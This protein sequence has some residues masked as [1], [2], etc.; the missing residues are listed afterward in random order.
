M[1]FAFAGHN[2]VQHVPELMSLRWSAAPK[3]ILVTA[4]VGKPSITVKAP[5]FIGLHCIRQH[6]IF[7]VF[8]IPK[9]HNKLGQESLEES[10]VERT[11]ALSS[12]DA[13]QVHAK[14]WAIYSTFVYSSSRIRRLDLRVLA[15]GVYVTAID[16]ISAVWHDDFCLLAPSLPITLIVGAFT[17]T[18]IFVLMNL[19]PTSR[20]IEPDILATIAAAIIYI[21]Y[22]YHSKYHFGTD[23][24]SR[25][26]F[27]KAGHSTS[28]SRL[29]SFLFSL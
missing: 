4:L 23:S 25:H 5:F 17:T 27:T 13:V 26:C 12:T 21:Y 9:P 29:S 16:A 7:A 1:A 11:Q 24:T 20:R 28:P 22:H 8:K 3:A 2:L 15:I 19:I 10:I 6:D 18:A 14:S